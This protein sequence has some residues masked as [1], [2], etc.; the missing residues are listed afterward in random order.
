MFLACGVGAF[1]VAIF[2]LFT[3]AFF[4]A[5][6]FLGSGSVIHAMSG[7]QDM[8]RMGGL[9]RKVP[10]TFWSFV[11]GTLAIAGIPPLA[12]YYSKDA[13]LAGALEEGHTALLAIGL[14]TALL[15]SFYMGR[16]L[17]LTFFGSF[18]GGE[19][20]EHH[21]HE[22]PWTMLG[23]LL[24]LAAGS[25]SAGYLGE[26]IWHLTSFL[27]P[28]FR[29]RAGEGH[30]A[31]WLPYVATL[32]ALLG[33]IAAWYAYVMFKELPGKLGAALR[34]AQRALEAKWGFDLLFDWIAGRVVVEGS[35]RALWKVFDSSL[36]DGAVN[37]TGAV[38]DA[39][40]RRV[41][42]VQTGLVRG[43]ALV[44]LGGA[45]ALLAYLL[46]L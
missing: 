8:R 23:P 36:I 29:L 39:V 12:G 25:A 41:R 2:H 32:T 1:G 33:L 30:H 13:I 24:V 31:T 46:W 19:Q 11:V 9:R 44:I 15:T 14:F 3:H 16:L 17:I 20:A 27:Q 21:V 37:G 22:S 35:R 28:A 4:K 6:L 34:P 26:R 43:Y 40:S 10:W 42:L 7:E 18:R 45:V 5:L 38:V